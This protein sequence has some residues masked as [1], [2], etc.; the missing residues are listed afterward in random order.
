MHMLG[1]FKCKSGREG[2]TVLLKS[3]VE[4]GVGR[5]FTCRLSPM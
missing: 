5:E 2:I 1:T 4:D 3:E